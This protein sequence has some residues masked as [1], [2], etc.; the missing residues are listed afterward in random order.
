M[1]VKLLR[2]HLLDPS[3]TRRR[4]RWV[5]ASVIAAIVAAVFTFALLV[6]IV[7]WIVGAT[8]YRWMT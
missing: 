5:L 7:A 6:G 8:I 3:A 1:N 2:A 4:S